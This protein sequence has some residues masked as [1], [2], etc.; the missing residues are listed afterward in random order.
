MNT[1][2]LCPITPARLD[3]L[4]AEIFFAGRSARSPEYQAGCRA[5]LSKRLS[6]STIEPARRR[7]R[8]GRCV[9]GGL[10]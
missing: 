2:S 9:V 8:C 3:Q 6:G 7:H 4:M 10:G 5:A 1:A